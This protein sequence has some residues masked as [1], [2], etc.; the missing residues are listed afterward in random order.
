MKTATVAGRFSP[1]NIS[2]DVIVLANAFRCAFAQRTASSL[3]SSSAADSAMQR[4]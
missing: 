2:A 3:S 4:L 1:G